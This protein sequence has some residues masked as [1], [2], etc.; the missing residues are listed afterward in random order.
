MAGVVNIHESSVNITLQP[1]AIGGTLRGKK[2]G[3]FWRPTMR[4]DENCCDPNVEAVRDMHHCCAMATLLSKFVL[5]LVVGV[6]YLAVR[7]LQ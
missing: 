1:I 3:T 5:A 2:D 4:P 6:I 7:L